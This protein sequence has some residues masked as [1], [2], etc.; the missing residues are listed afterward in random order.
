MNSSLA[1]NWYTLYKI[2]VTFHVYESRGARVVRALMN[3]INIEERFVT[4]N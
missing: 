4:L 1:R 3:E 2:V